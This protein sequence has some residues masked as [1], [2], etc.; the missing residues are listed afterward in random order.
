MPAA[1][2]PPSA[3]KSLAV[4]LTPV[5]PAGQNGGAK[6][7]ALELV[8]HLAARAPGTQF[9]LL[10]QSASHGELAALDA[11]NVRRI[12][13]VGAATSSLRASLFAV[14]SALMSLAPPGLRRVMARAGSRVNAALK[15]RGA[16]NMLHTLGT[17]LLFCPFTAPTY[18][19]AGIPVV[20]T[21]Y[22]LQYRAHPEFFAISDAVQ[23]ERALDE[24]CAAAAKLVAISDF[25]REAAIAECNL[26]PQRITTIYM[27]LASGNRLAPERDGGALARLALEEGNFL[28]YPANFW[29]HKNHEVLLQAF[30]M[31]RTMGLHAQVR[32]VCT[33]APGERMDALRSLTRELGLADHVV[34]PGFLPDDELGALMARC[35][36]VIYPS[37]YEGF[38]LPVIEAMA[39]GVPVACSRATALPEVAAD[40]A[41]Y[42]DPRD[43]AAIADAMMS[44]A[45]DGELRARLIAAG[46]KRAAEFADPDRMASEY[47]A[48]FEDAL[49]AMRAG[50]G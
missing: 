18:R 10:T 48:L 7:F 25:T 2:L 30:L 14:A 24:A 40:A 12:L 42:F 47:W 34:F 22:D 6:V 20:C 46:K 13:V 8:R 27:R 26:D 31:A 43:A 1:I 21:I 35:R 29:K 37:L 50:R 39:C 16:R 41:L 11:A 49:D 33:G 32:L 5:L 36:G 23:R 4:D 44:L 28:L 19:E 3:L 45:N 15:R 17:D 38:G 9:V